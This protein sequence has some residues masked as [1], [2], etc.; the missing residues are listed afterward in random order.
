MELFLGRTQ[1]NNAIAAATMKALEVRLALVS[2]KFADTLSGI[3]WI[4]M[5]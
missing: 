2:S 4:L 5:N 1:L 3:P